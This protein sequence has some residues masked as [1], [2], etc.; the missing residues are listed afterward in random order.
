MPEFL[1]SNCEGKILREVKR[2]SPTKSLCCECKKARVTENNARQNEKRGAQFWKERRTKLKEQGITRA[3]E[4]RKQ[5]EKDKESG[6]AK[7]QVMAFRERFKK[8]NGLE[9]GAHW[10]RKKR[11]AVNKEALTRLEQE[12]LKD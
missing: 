12:L 6:K 5:Y 9:Y 1:C 11:A 2:Y 4:R 7:E 10:E 3:E 8:E